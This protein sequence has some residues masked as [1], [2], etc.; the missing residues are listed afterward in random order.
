MRRGFRNYSTTFYLSNFDNAAKL[1]IR[2]YA[3]QSRISQMSV[4][5]SKRFDI[6]PDDCIE[7]P[8]PC[9]VETNK[10]SAMSESCWRDECPVPAGKIFIKRPVVK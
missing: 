6:L 9:V 3:F 4:D 7:K 2:R 5:L 10:S 1:L 8:R